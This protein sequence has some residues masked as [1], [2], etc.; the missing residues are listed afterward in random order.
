MQELLDGLPVALFTGRRLTYLLY[1]LLVLAILA[2]SSPAEALGLA[3]MASLGLAIGL[4]DVLG[5]A[6]R[7]GT[8]VSVGSGAS[9]GGGGLN[10]PAWPNNSA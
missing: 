5:G 3:L 1:A 9:V 6:V 7:L 2:R 4:A 8:G 10:R